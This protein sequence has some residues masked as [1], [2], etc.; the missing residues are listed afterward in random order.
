LTKEE[1]KAVKKL[2]GSFSNSNS[3]NIFQITPNHI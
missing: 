1:N 3:V 2:V